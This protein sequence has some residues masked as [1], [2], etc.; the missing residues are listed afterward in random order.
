MSD[1]INIIG[2]EVY[3]HIG[4]PDEERSRRQK[5]LVNLGLKVRCIGEAAVADNVK[6][7]VDYAQVANEVKDVASSRPRKLIETLAEDIAAAVLAH[8]LVKEVSVTIEKFILPDTRCVSVEIKR[9][10]PKKKKEKAP[11]SEPA[12]EVHHT[13]RLTKLRR[14][15]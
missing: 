7:T 13:K 6:L 11:E 4:V 14:P 1:R 9:K 2:L 8:E 15:I 5:L 3:S 12:A 10:A